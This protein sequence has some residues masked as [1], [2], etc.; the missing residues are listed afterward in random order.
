MASE[1][2]GEVMN[3]ETEWGPNDRARAE[4]LYESLHGYTKLF[5]DMLLDHPGKRIDADQIVASFAQHI[6]KGYD[7]PNRLSLAGSLTPIRQRC[8]DSGR[9]LPYERWTAPNGAASVYA[10]KPTVVRLFRDARMKIDPDYAGN[11][12][13]TDWSKAEVRAT[14][15][16]Y[17]EMLAAEASGRYYSKAAH[18]RKL[19]QQLS[20]VRTDSAIEFKYQNISAAMLD[21]GLP[22]IRGYRPRSNYQA[23]LTAEIQRRLEADPQLL[24]TLKISTDARP[25]SGSHL[26]RTPLPTP[27]APT[28]ASPTR[29]SRKGRHLDYGLLEEE[30]R[31]RGAQGERLVADYE[32]A[33][34]RHHGRNDLAS[35]VQWTA[36]DIG[37][38][39]GYDVL[40]FDLNGQE[41][42][43]EV[44][45]TALG[46]ET[47]FYITSAELDFAQRHVDR[48]ALYRVYDV[49]GNPRFF[50]LEGDITDALALTPAIYSARVAA[51][52]SAGGPLS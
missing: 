10:L 24:S 48:Y 45:A 16:D 22:Y 3:Q 51:I 44:K 17:L 38:G 25:P 9:P 4:E 14:V 49:L 8:K 6:P 39:L 34:L 2:R 12:R 36:R 20:A 33:W 40:S 28:A 32:R 18:R 52:T 27:S 19:R 1:F 13:R 41:R 23:A 50:G 11:V 29:T 26:Q 47:P 15:A 7:A 31:S 30:N 43:I 35:R 21:L 5:F 42:Y 37:D 46:A